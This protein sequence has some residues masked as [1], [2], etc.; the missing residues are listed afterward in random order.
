MFQDLRFAF[1][2]LA[3]SPGFTGIAALSLA[4]GIGST[5]TVFCWMQSVLLHPLPGVERDEEMVVL[6]TIHDTQMW[7]TVSLPDIRDF[8][9]LKEVFA[10]IIGSQIT[11]ACLT[12]DHKSE[13]IYGQVATADFFAVLGVKPILGRT[14][15]PGEDRKPGGNP[16]LVLSETFWR[17]R[18][19]GDSTVIGRD[20]ELNQHPFTIIGVVPATFHG[21]MSGLICDFWAP[22]SMCAE[23]A[24]FGSIDNRWDRWLHTQ[25]R[26]RPG[27]GLERAQAVVDAFA[28]RLE[29]AYPDSNRLI[30]LRVLPFAK[31][32]YGLQPVLG[33]AL[34]ILLAVSVGVLLIVAVNVAN[35]LLTRAT[36]RQKEIAIRL[37]V[38]ARR[39]RLIR[40]LLVESLLLAA[41]GG[42]LGVVLAYW[43]V[44]LLKAWMPHTYLPVG[45]SVR[46][47][48]LTLGFSVLLTVVTGV[49]FGLVPAVQ[50]SKPDLNSALKEGGRGSGAAAVHHRLRSFLV[51]AEIALSL[52]LLVGA[53]LCIKSVRRARQADLGFDPGHVLLAGLRIGMNG[54]TEDTARIFYRRLEER[55]A[56]IP[57]VQSA[58]LSSW[59]P[60]GFE[61]G[62]MHG[63]EVEGYVR[64]T[65]EDTTFP[66]SNISPGYF[67]VM[68]IPIVAGRDFTDQDDEK[69]P[70]AA[71]VNETMARR[72][73]PG[74]DPIGRTFKE[75]GNSTSV[76]GVARDGKYRSLN[77]PPRCFYYR[78]YQ[79]AVWDLNLGLCL[80]TA[81]DPAM[82]AS[83]LQQEIHK[84]DPRVEIW[85]VL[86]MTEFIK[87]V[88]LAPVLASRLLSWL[89]IVALALAAMGVYGVMAYVVGQ[90]TQE[91]GIRMAL[92]AGTGDV[93]GLIFREGLILAAAGIAIGL[94][95]AVA[96]T[97]LLAGF[98]IGISPFDPTIFIGV[99]ALLG[100]VALLACWLPARKATRVNPIEALRSE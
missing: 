72:F 43:A 26:L 2:T 60:L 22:V 39:G 99:P 25:A 67:D 35:L 50:A 9:E 87:A 14:F 83:S 20:V 74:L 11:P 58:A 55:S 57:G 1:R 100:A 77:E 88:Y 56:M 48:P 19:N 24:S 49:I 70:A 90:R 68:K 80:R 7:D 86:P 5:T 62:G 12:V 42:A 10:G 38:G 75:N 63:V 98:L 36:S 44:D 59:F 93:L 65:G 53:G 85:A 71:I 41:L 82:L 37:A 32:P 46:V 34:R 28:V 15:L 81:G 17:R 45:I 16:L 21:T 30:R 54:Y 33:M 84:L 31:A 18:F 3:K 13:W 91:F 95:L 92:G 78:P 29:K 76:V 8:R 40:Q 47:D 27:V 73:W 96:A 4:L 23:V 97:H 89:G 94:V 51:I 52:V 69:A 79:Q 64:K 66:Y 6:T 61:G